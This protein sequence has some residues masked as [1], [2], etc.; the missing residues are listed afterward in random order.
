L[1]VFHQDARVRLRPSEVR[2]LNEPRAFSAD[3]TGAEFATSFTGY[4]TLT[5][6]ASVGDAINL[7]SLEGAGPTAADSNEV[8]IMGELRP[9]ARLSLATSYLLTQ[10]RDPDDARIFSDHIVRT[11]LNYQ[12]TRRLA[13]RLIVQ[14]DHLDAVPARTS[15]ESRK[16][17][18]LDLLLTYLHTP[19]TAL[20]VGYNDNLQNLDPSLRP[21][22][23]GLLRTHR[24]LLSDGRQVFIKASYLLRR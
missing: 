12:F 22:P 11:K 19:G 8:S 3:R 20:Y 4:L 1:S 17:L 7:D 10:L 15:I 24:G 23:S 6:K 2:T 21:G 13:A 18:N 14:Y 16:N 9:G 5:L